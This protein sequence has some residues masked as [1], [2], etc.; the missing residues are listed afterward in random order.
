MFICSLHRQDAF[1]QVMTIEKERSNQKK[2]E[3]Q[4]GWY[5]EYDM[6]ETLGW[7]PYLA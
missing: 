3:T 2:L 4:K 1:L 5:S 7:K 6:K